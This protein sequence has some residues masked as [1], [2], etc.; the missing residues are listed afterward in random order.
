MIRIFRHYISR[1]YLLLMLIEFSMFFAAMYLG[2]DIRFLMS[3]SWYTDNYITLVKW[4][5]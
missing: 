1:A 5:N 2:S 3:E 4:S